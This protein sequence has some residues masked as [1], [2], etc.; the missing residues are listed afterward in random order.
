MLFVNESQGGNVKMSNKIPD[1]VLKEIFPKKIER[2]LISEQIYSYI[3]KMILSGKL[4]K[5]Q[6]LLRWDFIQ[7]FEVNEAA[8]SGAFSK[9]RKDGLIISKGNKG[10]F[11]A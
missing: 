5:G 2:S 6:R 7:I 3:K 8:V 4:K 9:L 11:V 1:E 10:S